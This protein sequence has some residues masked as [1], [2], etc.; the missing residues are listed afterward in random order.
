MSCL[1]SAR[2]FDLRKLKPA[3]LPRGERF[4]TLADAERFWQLVRSRLG[5]PTSD[6]HCA[7][8]EA[9]SE[10][11]AGS[12]PCNRVLCPRCGRRVRGWAASE[13]LTL[14]GEATA[15]S[16]F[17]TVYGDEVPA[18]Q[19]TLEAVKRFRFRLRR[20]ILRFGLG[21]Q[22][23]VGGIEFS[24]RAD[25]GMWLLHSHLIWIS[26][27]PVELKAFVRNL[28]RISGGRAPTCVARRIDSPVEAASY[29]LKFALVHRPGQRG[30]SK[31]PRAQLLPREPARE[32]AALYL[33]SRF[34]DFLFLSGCRRRGSKIVPAGVTT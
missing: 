30:G 32:L 17:L 31:R 11:V 14:M 15:D 28:R 19:L 6:F 8:I 33:H 7:E 22:P 4:E 13:T 1:L 29:A 21:R 34:T 26:P 24:W 3:S 10:C 16:W 9:I 18:G 25:S 27:D 20:R 12:D 2:K 23:I 5:A